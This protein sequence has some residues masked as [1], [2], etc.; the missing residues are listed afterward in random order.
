MGQERH[1]DCRIGSTRDDFDKLS[2]DI[3]TLQM[4]LTETCIEIAQCDV[5]KTLQNSVKT[6]K[7]MN[8]EEEQ[9]LR[10]EQNSGNIMQELER[11]YQEERL[12]SNRAIDETDAKIQT[13]RFEVEDVNLYGQHEVEYF[14]KWEKARVEQNRL[15]WTEKERHHQSE[16]EKM[17][18]NISLE[19]KCHTALVN[20]L[21]ESRVDYLD[22]IQ[23]WMK[24]YDE[25]TEQLEGDMI[26]LRTDLER[27]T[28]DRIRMQKEFSKRSDEI[29]DW[30]EY[31]DIKR[32]KE[33]QELKEISAATK[34]QAWW[35][36]V[37]YRKKLGP[38]RKKKKGKKNKKK[39][40]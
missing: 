18:T 11:Q 17:A 14:N 36:A 23:Y 31:K 38:Y 24:R 28:L 26:R 1:A 12:N 13:L 32:Q 8:E 10:D 3:V 29:S 39:K 5:Y 30:L 15:K 22:D 40:K 7:L 2:R 34:I 33:E 9:L 25:E 6:I 27:I 19:N 4:I 35:R 16:M 21:N 37:M 20:F